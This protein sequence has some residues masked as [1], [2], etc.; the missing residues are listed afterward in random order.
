MNLNRP[1][2]AFVISVFLVA[3]CADAQAEYLSRIEVVHDSDKTDIVIHFDKNVL[4][5]RFFPQNKAKILFLKL[6]LIDTQPI[7]EEKTFVEETLRLKPTN[8]FPGVSVSYA[9]NNNQLLVTF[10]QVTKYSVRPGEDGRSV[11]ITLLPQE[12]VAPK[13]VLVQPK[14]SPLLAPTTPPASTSTKIEE[15]KAS[16]AI[17]SGETPSLKQS[18]ETIKTS[19]VDSPAIEPKTA[20]VVPGQDRTPAEIERL[21]KALLEEAQSALIAK[22]PTTAVNRL[23]RILRFPPSGQTQSA[24][25]LI[26]EARELNGEISK[27]RAEYETYLKLYPNGVEASRIREHL[28]ILPKGNIRA[29]RPLPKEAGPA[30]WSVFG[31]VSANY[32]GGS[33]LIDTTTVQGNN[34]VNQNRLAT[35]DQKSLITSVNLNARRR[36]AFSDTRIVVRDT[37]N[38]DSLNSSRSYNRLFSAYIDHNDKKIGYYV[39]FG[40]QNPNGIGVFERFDGLQAG[41]NLNPEWRVNGV[42][43]DAVEF[44]SPFKREFYGASVSLCNYCYCV[45]NPIKMHFFHSFCF[46]VY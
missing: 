14:T 5:E 44:N 42:Y 21:S 8:D 26:G 34:T 46:R 18:Q 6:R 35:V 25:A 7:N 15:Q 1:L 22:D 31:N 37:N 16:A 24:Q 2:S 4:F 12:E 38:K 9:N 36:D 17:T 19:P 28:A 23:N 43:G 32:F 45:C 3:F 13:P 33:S 10:P 11:V 30:E 40:R 39:R 41:Y 20:I 27:A 29:P